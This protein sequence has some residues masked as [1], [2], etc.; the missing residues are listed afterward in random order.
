MIAVEFNNN[1]EKFSLENVYLQ[2]VE[3]GFLPGFKLSANLLRFYPP[4]T[5]KE[6]DINS[7]ISSLDQVI[8]MIE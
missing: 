4:L 7:M 6:D 5:I 2:L 1:T 3:K 8:S